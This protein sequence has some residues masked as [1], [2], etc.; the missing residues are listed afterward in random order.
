PVRRASRVTPSSLSATLAR[1]RACSLARG[2]RALARTFRARSLARRRGTARGA[3]LARRRLRLLRQR[4]LRRRATAFATKR[5]RRRPRALRR[6]PLLRRRTTRC[7][8][9]LGGL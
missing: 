4:A 2:G 7:R 9:A 5:L 6:R 1:P 8:R 3:A